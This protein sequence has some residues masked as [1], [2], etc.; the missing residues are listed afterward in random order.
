MSV[1]DRIAERIKTLQAKAGELSRDERLVTGLNEVR[2][3]ARQL[4][5]SATEAVSR[6]ATRREDAAREAQQPGTEG[7]AP[8][9]DAKEVPPAAGVTTSRDL[10]VHEQRPADAGSTPQPAAPG[11]RVRIEALRERLAALGSDARGAMAE[12]LGRARE[13]PAKLPRLD[14]EQIARL[15]AKLGRMTPVAPAPPTNADGSPAAAAPPGTTPAAAPVALEP[16]AAPDGSYTYS[17]TRRTETFAK[18]RTWP[19]RFAYTLLTAAVAGGILHILVVLAVPTL[20]W[21][22]AFSRLAADLPLNK[23]VILPAS[24]PGRSVLPFLA[25][26]MRYAMCRYEVIGGPVKVTATLPEV[27][28]SLAVYTPQGDNFYAAPA[29][30][31]RRTDLAFT[32]LPASDRLINLTPGQRRADVDI[33]SVTSPSREGLI[34]LRAPVKGESYLSTLEPFL[35]SA[36]C[37]PVGR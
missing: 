5:L 12:G 6:L 26:D 10:V 25:P 33:G 21:G 9:P 3:R 22:S 7:S 27:G 35:R 24:A 4:R 20:G 17:P 11:A 23:M 1:S 34:V 16:I 31:T 18:A 37:E 29:H 36:S 8:A 13:L 28:W 30:E 32:L 14:G 2:D 15:K 19:T